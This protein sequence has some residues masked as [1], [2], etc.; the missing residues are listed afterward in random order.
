[1]SYTFY[2]KI[3]LNFSKPALFCGQNKIIIIKVQD[4]QY[5]LKHSEYK[6]FCLWLKINK[7]SY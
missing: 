4:C 1:M 7:I 2:S 5:V 6:L 3:I